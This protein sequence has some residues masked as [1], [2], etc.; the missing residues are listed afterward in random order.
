MDFMPVIT[1]GI[2]KKRDDFKMEIIVW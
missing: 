1:G 2:I